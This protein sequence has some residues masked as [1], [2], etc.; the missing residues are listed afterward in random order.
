MLYHTI[1]E[2]QS[3][4][5]EDLDRFL[6]GKMK[7]FWLSNPGVVR[8]H[9]FGDKLANKLERVIMIEIGSFGELDKIL[10]LEERKALRSELLT[11]TTNLQS[12]I[13]EMIE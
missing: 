11:L 1:C 3:G 12:R 13:L 9:V 10:D 5:E 2:V 4:R 6:V 8:F 7:K